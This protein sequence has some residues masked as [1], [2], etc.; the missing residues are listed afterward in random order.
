MRSFRV[1]SVVWNRSLGIV[2]LAIDGWDLSL[3]VFRVGSVAWKFARDLSFGSFRLG[4][5]G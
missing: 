5:F 2:R 4:S 1:K 3:V